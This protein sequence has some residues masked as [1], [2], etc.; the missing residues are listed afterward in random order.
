M[1]LRSYT[2]K[3]DLNNKIYIPFY[4]MKIDLI[5]VITDDDRFYLAEPLFSNSY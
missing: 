1:V 3:I 2:I 5:I 4:R